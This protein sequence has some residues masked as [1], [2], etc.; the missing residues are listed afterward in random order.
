[1]TFDIET[2]EKLIEE[3]SQETTIHASLKLLS[4]G[5]GSNFGYETFI[6]RQG[7]ECTDALRMV[8]EFVV[9]LE[10]ISQMDELKL[11][12]EFDIATERLLN[13]IE[14]GRAHKRLK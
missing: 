14:N 10:S 13:M 6:M 9:C 1:V 3:K 5:I 11:P 2:Y 4:I 12:I 7:D 8:E